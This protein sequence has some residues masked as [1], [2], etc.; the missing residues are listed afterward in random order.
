MAH[1]EELVPGS[2]IAVIGMACRFPGAKN[3]AEYWRNLRD[4]VESVRFMTDE[5]LAAAGVD[6][7]VIANPDY[8]KA[9]IVL[10]EMEMF[11]AG[12]FGFS[13][14]DAAIMDP[15]HRHF[16]ECSWE[17]LESAGHNPDTFQ[18]SI[19]V[20]GGCGMGAYF[21]YNCLTNRQLMESTGLFLVRHTGNDKDFLTTRVSYQFNLRGPSVNVQTACSTS[22]VAIHLAC[23]NLLN[24]ECDMALAG[25]VT[26]EMPH[27]RGYMY[28]D[29]EILSRDGHCRSFDHRSTGTIF[30]SGAGVVVLRRLEDALRDGDTIHAV[31][32]GSAINNDGS[33]KVGYLAPSVDGQAAAISEA[34]NVA[35]FPADTVTYI[36]THGTGTAVGDPIEITAL[37]DAF[38][39]TTDKKGF[40]GIGS[41]KTNIGHLDTA[42]GVAS[43]IKAVQALWHKQLPPSLHF[44]KPNPLIDFA[45][46]P[47][48]VNALLQDWTPPAGVARRA[49]VSSLGVGGTNA[50]V[51]IEEAPEVKSSAPSTR[52]F[53]LLAISARTE[54]S[55][56]R[57]M[58][59][60]SA[61]FRAEPE[62]NLADVAYTL[63]V[64]RKPFRYRRVLVARDLEDAACAL[65][66]ADP[67]RIFTHQAQQSVPS[68]VFLFPGGG[69]QYPQMGRDLYEREEVYRRH[70]DE[71]LAILQP[72]INVDLKRLMFPPENEL[73]TAGAQLERPL[74]SILSI[75]ITEYALAKLWMSWGVMPAAMTGHSLG[76]YTAAC[77]GEVISPEEAISLVVARGKIFERMPAGGMLSVQAPEAEVRKLLTSSMSIAAANAPATCV[78][79]GEDAALDELAKTLEAREIDCARLKI[80]VAAHSPMLD[81]FLD[82]FAAHARGFTLRAPSIPY[83]SNLTGN[84]VKQEDLDASYWVR[85]LRNTVRFADGLAVLLEDPNRVLIEVG[86][87][88]TLSSLVRQQPGKKPAHVVLNSMRHPKETGSDVQY[89]LSTFGRLWASGVNVDWTRLYG[90]ERRRRIP[91]PTYSFDHQRHWIEPGK[92]LYASAAAADG[93]AASAKVMRSSNINDWFYRPEWKKAPLVDSAAP[94]ARRCWLIFR[95][96]EGLGAEIAD[97]L[98]T[99][100][101]DVI[102]VDRGDHF[103]G[104]SETHYVINPGDRTEYDSLVAALI[105][106]GRIPQKVLHLWTVARDAAADSLTALDAQLNSSFFSLLFFTQAL[107]GED[108]VDTLDITIVATGIRQVDNQPETLAPERATLFGPCLVIPQ[109][110]PGVTCRAVDVVLPRAG[111][112]SLAWQIIA[113]GSTVAPVDRVIAYRGETRWVET[114]AQSPIEAGEPLP[115]RL[116][117][118][119]VYL[120]TGGLGDIALIQADMLARKWQA[121]LAL[122]SRTG[123]PARE[124][125]AK[126]LETH[127]TDDFTAR[128]IRHVQALEAQGSEVLIVRADVTDLAQFQ[129]AV[130][131]TVTQFGAIHGVIHTAGIIN[132]GVI[133]EKTRREAESV[134]APKVRGTMVIEEALRGQN[135]DFVLLFSSTSALLGLAGQVDYTAANAF[136]DAWAQSRSGRNAPYTVSVDWGVWQGVGMAETA[137]RQRDAAQGPARAM[138]HPLLGRCTVDSPSLV[139]YEADY[140]VDGMWVLSEHKLK[141]G[142]CL[143]PGTGYL[144]LAKAALEKGSP[145][146][147]EIRDLFFLAPLEVKADSACGVGVTLKKEGGAF[148]LSVTS[149]TPAGEMEH[150]RAEVSFLHA[151]EAPRDQVDA[152]S[153]RCVARV[154]RPEPGRPQTKQEDHLDFGPRWKNLVEMRFGKSEALALLELPQDNA[155]DLGVWTLHPSV[156]DQ[157]TCFALPLLR[158][159]DKCNDLFVP[160]SYKRVRAYTSLP[161][162]VW[163]HVRLKRDD[164]VVNGVAVF[165]VRIMDDTGSVLV[166]V[167][168][169]AVRRLTEKVSGATMGAFKT[170]AATGGLAQPSDAQSRLQA[171]VQDG[172]RPAEGADALERILLRGAAAQFVA[173]PLALPAL[174]EQTRPKIKTTARSGDAAV[175]EGADEIETNLLHWWSDLLGVEKVGLTDDFFD[176]GGQSLVAV[177]LFTKIKKTYQVDLGL[178]T[179]FEARTVRQLAEVL[180]NQGAKGGA[181]SS[182]SALVPLQKGNGTKPILFCVHG[183]GGNVLGYNALVRYLPPDQPFYAIQGQGL[184]R[185]QKPIT[186]MEEMAAYYVKEIRAV[187]PQGPYYLSGYSFGGVAAFEMACQLEAAGERVAFLLMFDSDRPNSPVSLPTSLLLHAELLW[188]ASPRDKLKHVQRK[189]AAV[190]RRLRKSK[191]K[192]APLQ[193]QESSAENF[194]DVRASN[195]KAYHGYHSGIYPGKITLFRANKLGES[196]IRTPDLGWTGKALGGIETHWIPGDHID[197]LYEPNVPV[198]ARKLVECLDRA[199]ADEAARRTPQE[200]VARR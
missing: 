200:E 169:F 120:I 3:P 4:G 86:P 111:S 70:A 17:A 97:Q 198:P 118:Q 72:Q 152:I 188:K 58:R 69:A 110:F 36:E 185:K 178:A 76:E 63:A 108:L 60:L 85:H 162:R 137:I 19:G 48:Y 7:A 122:V 90:D 25:G 112:G 139:A 101:Q 9:S 92:A 23:Q 14:K 171:W 11:D 129:R 75:F 177:R 109:E 22:L 179:L 167:E 134:L 145:A 125:W 24:G 158:D 143:L 66:A 116:R 173:S 126:W 165:D 67:K 102:T 53:E 32:K 189:L 42:A 114:W 56:D 160:L 199:Y 61:Q 78:V 131:E 98:H 197:I 183:V 81:P 195:F 107:A 144:E 44:E 157:A 31:I 55:L 130:N 191:A 135:P 151:A 117:K 33:Q 175:V 142:E 193:P 12:F 180:R 99:M 20:Y 187:Q 8:V 141:G 133:Q 194:R 174:I 89:Y 147:V 47:F 59:R 91:L 119:G 124:Q 136:L 64:G 54:A 184:N 146:A 96:S 149:R 104:L 123:L 83:V 51:V 45:S 127:S 176:L 18:G 46:S 106:N 154:V 153:A 79:S 62:T 164:H 40:C 84:W 52:P 156:M 166:E 192:K 121:R 182:W 26:I 68:I 39:R 2:D 140:R 170:A 161:R 6:S 37:T 10:E 100:G 28:Q 150:A 128:R 34:L 155:S 113:E 74:Y 73:E 80:S 71:C 103:Q 21:M 148:A 1:S 87:G 41:V 49:G 95:D 115:S 50:H 163:S 186:K 159:Y 65:E 181:E 172:I 190:L 138:D 57:A 27:Y 168:E 196:G 16:L 30:G 93:A 88:T 35:G 94:A 15:Q 132:D 29:G 38:R 43:F 105:E 13:P 5:E 77:L 82:E